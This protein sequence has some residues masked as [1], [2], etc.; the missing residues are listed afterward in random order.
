VT[1]VAGID[2]GRIAAVHQAELERFAAE[3]P[4]SREL[5]E[6]GRG[7]LVSGVPMTWMAKWVGGYPVYAA[8]ARGAMIEDV[9]GHRYVDFSLGDTGAMA[10]HSPPP[11]VAAIERRLRDLGGATLMLPTEDAAAVGEE[12]ARRFGMA[13]WS[14][15]LTATD[16]NRWALRLCREITRRPQVLVFNKMDRLPP[17]VLREAARVAAAHSEAKHSS[18]IPVD[19]TFRR[20][21]R[22]PRGSAPGSVTYT[23]EKTVD[24]RRD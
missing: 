8:R 10:G 16:A 5:F 11:T 18:V 4:R 6:R 22:K 17:E 3:H 14:F 7:S 12:L 13:Q 19:Y 1:D 15:S 2:H 23:G 9:D 24:V 20:Y 21:V